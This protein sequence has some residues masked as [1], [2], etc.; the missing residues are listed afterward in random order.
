MSDQIGT[1]P[2]QDVIEAFKAGKMIIMVD[3]AKRE[4]E[5]DLVI[6]A[7]AVTP[8][9]IAF[10]LRYGRGLIC[11]S[12]SQELAQALDLP[13]QVANNNSAFATPFAVSIDHRSVHPNGITASGRASTIQALV[14]EGAQSQD[15][16][17]PGNVFPLIAN[18]AGVI[19]RQ[20]QTEGSY[21]LAR[22]C[23]FKSAGV[24][25]E[26]LNPDGSMARG[27]DLQRFAE[28]HDL[29]ITSVEEI[30]RYR[31]EH[32]TLIR[33]VAESEIETD[34]GIFEVHVFQD[35]VF[36]KEHLA[37]V[38]GELTG[39]ATPLVRIHSECLTGDVF[40]SRRC[41]CGIQLNSAMAAIVQ[42]GAGVLL[43][44]RQ[45]GRGIGLANKLRAYALQDQGADTVE[46]NLQ[47]GFKADER[48][49]AVA[50]KML[51]TLQVGR[52]RLMTNNPDKIQS[53]ESCGIVVSERQPILAVPDEYNC[54]YL[55]TKREKLGHLL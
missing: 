8:A 28:Q 35:D 34:H 29:L 21:D 9:A 46:A 26:I 45:E 1:A 31:A 38:Y 44:L 22:I 50:A 13:F 11:V 19:G 36:D 54:N 3:D 42:A 12:I 24:I 41:D 37:L 16:L 40:E 55:A 43:Y 7:E 51:G 14:R 27:A 25:C 39:V 33:R 17:A 20:G 2:F 47:L 48:N 5:G 4:N 30:I 6:A 32:D 18:P 10:M 52:V 15:F 23:G 49:F 53:L